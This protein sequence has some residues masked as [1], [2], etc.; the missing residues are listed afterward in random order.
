MDVAGEWLDKSQ[1]AADKRVTK[2]YYWCKMR[3]SKIKMVKLLFM[4][5]FVRI[6][7]GNLFNQSPELF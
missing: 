1:V 7:F 4:M 2:E 6:V 5:S 3:M